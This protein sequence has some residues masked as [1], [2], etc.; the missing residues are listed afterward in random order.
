MDDMSNVIPRACSLIYSLP[1]FSS[2][3]G[4]D[5][6]VARLMH[7]MG[8]MQV[9]GVSKLVVFGG[10]GERGILLDSIEEWDEKEEKWKISPLKLSKPKVCIRY[11][12]KSPVPRVN[13]SD[14]E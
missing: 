12:F 3:I 9:G 10:V 14:I 8:T 2:I 1:D 5:L 11:C 4:P 6:N 7:G 13:V